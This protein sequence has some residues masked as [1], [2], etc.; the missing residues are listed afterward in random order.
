MKL[1]IVNL[2]V[3]GSNPVV[4]SLYGRVAQRIEQDVSPNLVVTDEW[5]DMANAEETT[6][7]TLREAGS[8]PALLAIPGGG[9][10]GCF[11]NTGR[12]G[13]MQRRMPDGTTA[14]TVG[15]SGRFDS[16]WAYA[17]WHERGHPVSS[18]LVAAAWHTISLFHGG[19]NNPAN[20]G[21]T[22]GKERPAGFLVGRSDVQAIPRF[23]G[24]RSSV[25]CPATS[26]RW[27]DEKALG[28]CRRG[29][30]GRIAP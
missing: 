13:Q 12:H 8:N 29:N 20:A 9:P 7:V 15:W 23:D 28:E 21:R 26:C 3:A 22:T 27:N 30:R 11:F 10:A 19:W 14:T 1:Q 17:L 18:I 25:N 24:A 5:N 2:Q 4:S 16:S 6:L